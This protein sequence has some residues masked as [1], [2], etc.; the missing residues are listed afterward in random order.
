MWPFGIVDLNCTGTESSVFN[1]SYSGMGSC[2][3]SHDASAICRG[4]TYSWLQYTCTFKLCTF[5]TDDGIQPENCT[6]GDVRLVGGVLESEGRLEV[7]INQVWGT[8][9]SR[10]WSSADSRVACRQLGH[11]ELGMVS[12]LKA[13]YT[14]DK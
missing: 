9:C 12:I 4:N 7:C 13:L 2:E 6:T 10:S 11:Q 3:A 14:Y 8:V 1:C 5:S